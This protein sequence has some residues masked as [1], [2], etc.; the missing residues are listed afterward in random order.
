[1]V[2]GG[3]KMLE[4]VYLAMEATRTIRKSKNVPVN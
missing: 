1:M 4:Y 2:I 3:T